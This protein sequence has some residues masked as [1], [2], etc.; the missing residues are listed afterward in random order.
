MLILS[1]TIVRPGRSSEVSIILLQ[2]HR[3]ERIED[4]S[5]CEF[6]VLA[7]RMAP[8]EAMKVIRADS[9]VTCDWLNKD[10]ES[11]QHYYNGGILLYDP[12]K[13]LYDK[14]RPSLL[15]GNRERDPVDQVFEL[16]PILPPELA[17]QI[18][19]C[20]E[21]DVELNELTTAPAK[22]HHNN[23]E[24][25]IHALTGMKCKTFRCPPLSAEN[26]P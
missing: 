20:S 17:L 8:E 18:R 15:S 21:E 12:T 24:L 16:E 14:R 26:V 9:L 13:Q 19:N 1:Q 3:N 6:G 25:E 11:P 5:D 4:G 7:K 2:K 23:L 22:F 10:P